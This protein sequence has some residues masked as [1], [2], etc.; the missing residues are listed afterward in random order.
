MTISAI[1]EWIKSAEKVVLIDGCFL[2]CHGRIL[3]NLLDED[4]LIVF[5]ALSHYN[6]YSDLFLIDDVP[7]TE[8][9]EAARSVADWVLAS[10]K[11][12]S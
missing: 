8:R 10:L 2:K 7:E 5:D 3:K 1:A 4:R 11:D 9:K 6:K 12:G